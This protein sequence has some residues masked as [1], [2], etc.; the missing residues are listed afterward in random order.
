MSDNIIN[1]SMTGSTRYHYDSVKCENCSQII[2][3]KQSLK[4]HTY[5]PHKHYLFCSSCLKKKDIMSRTQAKRTFFLCDD[6]IKD[7]KYIHVHD[8]RRFFVYD[9]ILQVVIQKYGS[10]DEYKMVAN[11]RKNRVERIRRDKGKKKDE[12]EQQLFQELKNNKLEYKTYGDCY[13]FIHYGKPDIKTVI[14][15]ELD[16]VKTANQKR[17]DL[18]SELEKRGVRLDVTSQSYYDYINNISSSTLDEVVRDIEIE[19]FL[20]SK[21]NYNDLIKIHP[22]SEAQAIALLQYGQKNNHQPEFIP[23]NIFV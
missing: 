19:I 23:K 8:H 10:F 9:D 22:P 5:S 7:L 12:R 2:H 6:E 14:N 4:I 20:K 11:E 16:K 17:I 13:S 21:T 3:Q 18:A 1:G 15:N